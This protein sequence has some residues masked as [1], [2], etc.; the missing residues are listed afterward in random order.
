MRVAAIE[1]ARA[2]LER[3]DT[4]LAVACIELA[5]HIIATDYLQFAAHCAGHCFAAVLEAHV[6]HVPVRGNNTRARGSTRGSGGC[7]GWRGA[8]QRRGWA[9]A[10]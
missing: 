6:Q 9:V 10:A 7:A 5:A 3:H 2:R 1:R 4:K 8:R